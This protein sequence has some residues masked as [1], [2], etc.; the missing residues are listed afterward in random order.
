[1]F[2]P[3][4]RSCMKNRLAILLLVIFSSTLFGNL[5]TD[6]GAP[7]IHAICYGKVFKRRSTGSSDQLLSM[8]TATFRRS[9]TDDHEIRYGGQLYDILS[10]T[11]RGNI[12]QLQVV[13]DEIETKIS[14]IFQQI[15]ESVKKAST[16]HH[17][18]KRMISWLLKLYCPDGE[19]DELLIASKNLSQYNNSRIPPIYPGIHTLC[20]QPP[21]LFI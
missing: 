14:N 11:A 9:M 1:M 5:L 3:Y 7:F 10:V 16:P 4:F 19:N 15:G 18:G 20:Q 6:F 21:E 2:S 17:R 13:N 8:D 12:V